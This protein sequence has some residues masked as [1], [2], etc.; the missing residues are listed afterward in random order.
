MDYFSY[1]QKHNIMAKNINKV[2]HVY[3]VKVENDVRRLIFVSSHHF[4]DNAEQY[5]ETK[6]EDGKFYSIE[7]EYYVS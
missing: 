5:I 4:Y 6:G 3:E 2:Y 7:K 1:I